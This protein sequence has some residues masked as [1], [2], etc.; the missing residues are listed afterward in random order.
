MLWLQAVPQKSLGVTRLDIQPWCVTEAS[1]CPALSIGSCVTRTNQLNSESFA[2]FSSWVKYLPCLSHKAGRKLQALSHEFTKYL[3][4][5]S[6]H[7]ARRQRVTISWEWGQ[8]CSPKWQYRW[9]LM[10]NMYLWRKRAVWG[11]SVS[12]ASLCYRNDGRERVLSFLCVLASDDFCPT[13]SGILNQVKETTGFLDPLPQVS[14][15][16]HM[17]AWV[18][19]LFLFTY[20]F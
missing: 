20:W 1:V 3:W 13:F 7:S 6:L 15:W 17:G 16:A 18:F 12:V 11:E 4:R 8:I 10:Q 5:T 2:Q 19:L 14:W 9:Q